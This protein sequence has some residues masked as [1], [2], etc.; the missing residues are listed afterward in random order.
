MTHEALIIGEDA[1]EFAPI[2]GLGAAA[3]ILL[4]IWEAVQLVE[5]SFITQS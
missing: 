2:P 3:G 5:V 1:L 4:N